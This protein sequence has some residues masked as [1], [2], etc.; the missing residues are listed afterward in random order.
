VCLPPRQAGA[1]Q[2]ASRGLE[3][4]AKRDQAE[5]ERLVQEA[6]SGG[7]GDAAAKASALHQ[8]A[9]HK[10]QASQLLSAEAI[11]G[12]V[13][14]CCLSFVVVLGAVRTINGSD[15]GFSY[16]VAPSDEPGGSVLFFAPASPRKRR[17]STTGRARG[18][19][20]I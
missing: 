20:A 6:S 12:C 16:V 5:S 13:S 18:D 15:A 8:Q 11:S 2:A 10:A 17:R 19:N 14:T 3:E 7:G 4:A 1:Q 9:E